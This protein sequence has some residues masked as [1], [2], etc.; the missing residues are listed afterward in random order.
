MATTG[1]QWGITASGEAVNLLRC[2]AMK[3]TGAGTHWELINESGVVLAVRASKDLA[4]ATIV[5]LLA[6]VKSNIDG[7]VTEVIIIDDY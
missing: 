6:Q 2:G 4:A 1:F 5:A 7:G 3:I